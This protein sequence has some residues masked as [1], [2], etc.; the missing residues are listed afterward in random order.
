MMDVIIGIHRWKISVKAGG[1]SAMKTIAYE[2]EFGEI[3]FPEGFEE[4]LRGKALRNR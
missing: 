1:R 3:E 2:E 4:K